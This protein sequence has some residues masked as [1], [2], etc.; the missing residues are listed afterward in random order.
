MIAVTC[1]TMLMLSLFTPV[2]GEDLSTRGT[3]RNIVGGRGTGADF[4]FVAK[5]SIDGPPFVA[6]C[7]G[8]LIRSSVVLTAAHCFEDIENIER[9]TVVFKIRGREWQAKA[10][11]VLF[12]RDYKH[13]DLISVSDIALVFLDRNIYL[14]PIRI[15]TSEE[16]Q[17]YIHKGFKAL[18]VGW[19]A[20]RHGDDLTNDDFPVDLQKVVVSILPRSHCPF[21]YRLCAG[22]EGEGTSSGDS[23]SPLLVPTPEGWAQIGVSSTRNTNSSNY[24]R[25][26]DF[27][28]WIGL[29][30][31]PTKDERTLYFPHSVTGEGWKSELLLM[32]ISPQTSLDMQ[33]LQ[34]YEGDF[35]ETNFGLGGPILGFRHPLGLPGSDVQV[36]GVIVH[37]DHEM[38]GLLRLHHTSGAIVGVGPSP[39]VRGIEIPIAVDPENVHRVGYAVF[40]PNRV[41][42]VR[43]KRVLIGR[44]PRKELEILHMPP[45]GHKAMFIDESLEGGLQQWGDKYENGVFGLIVEECDGCA[46]KITAVALEVW[47]NQLIE[48]PASLLK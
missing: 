46:K 31:T 45:G 18:A 43:V 38:T 21:D 22:E 14:E 27:L 29:T 41:L 34:V 6:N 19:G 28:I 9:V 40:N 48:I 39:L 8:T 25:T 26:A 36:G 4:Y 33:I 35:H 12:P 44:G 30:N 5:I 13:E 20:T 1:L 32:P 23:G 24:I 47:G 15:L 16:E 10:L 17:S 42:P 37:S 11:Q 7:T 3:Q 2:F